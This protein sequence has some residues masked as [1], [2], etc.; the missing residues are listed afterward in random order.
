MLKQPVLFTERLLLRP[1]QMVDFP[2]WV[3]MMADPDAARFIGGVQP[4]ASVWRG[5]MGMAGAWQLSGV[6]MFSV[7]DRKSGLWLGRVGPWQPEGWP[8]AEV[9]WG[10]H[11]DAQGRGYAFE[12]ASACMAYARDVLGWR[13]IIHTIDPANTAS[14]RLAERLGS[15]RRGPGKLPAPYEEANVDIWGTPIES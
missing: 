13:D 7:I 12:A 8:G 15:Q 14:I 6:S 4:R 3:E 5:M 10:L 11:P 1:P 9:G 2:R